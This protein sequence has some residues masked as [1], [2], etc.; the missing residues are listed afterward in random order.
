VVSGGEKEGI[1]ALRGR[2]GTAKIVIKALRVKN[3]KKGKKRSWKQAREEEG[4]GKRGPGSLPAD[5]G[6]E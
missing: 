5:P 4:A 6:P 2:I 1:V 3:R